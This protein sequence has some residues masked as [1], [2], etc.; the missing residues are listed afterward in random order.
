M[1]EKDL[2]FEESSKVQYLTSA[3]WPWDATTSRAKLSAVWLV[4]TCNTNNWKKETLDFKN[5]HITQRFQGRSG[6]FKTLS[7]K[8]KF[9]DWLINN[10]T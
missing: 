2:I 5:I 7:K 6:L 10:K 9:K 4:H 1:L 8:N 3:V